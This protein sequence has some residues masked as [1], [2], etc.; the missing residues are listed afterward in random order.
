MSYV[1]YTF[2]VR[3]L[4]GRMQLELTNV[5]KTNSNMSNIITF[6]VSTVDQKIGIH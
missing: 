6:S 3:I 1:S 4:K 2:L 5:Q